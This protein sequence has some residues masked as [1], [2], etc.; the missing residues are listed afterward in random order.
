M[1]KSQDYLQFSDSEIQKFQFYYYK[2]FGE[3]ISKEEA[4]ERGSDLVIFLRTIIF[5]SNLLENARKE[6]EQKMKRTC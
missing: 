2:H 6:R 4:I 1:V 5:D 3:K